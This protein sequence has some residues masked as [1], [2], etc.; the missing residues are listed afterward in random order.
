[1]CDRTGML[2]RPGT[3]SLR[4]AGV[5]IDPDNSAADAETRRAAARRGYCY[6]DLQHITDW[7]IMSSEF[8]TSVHSAAVRATRL[9]IACWAA[10][11]LSFLVAPQ[12]L[13]APVAAAAQVAQPGIVG[14]WAITVVR[15]DG[16]VERGNSLVF[17]VDGHVTSAGPGGSGGGTWSA[18]GP[19][20]FTYSIRTNYDFGY[21]LVTAKIAVSGDRLAGVG[22]ATAYDPQGT[23]LGGGQSVLAG[24][25]S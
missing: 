5:F 17:S 23:Q 11:A 19:R 18:A 9:V 4:L 15:A 3:T 2:G 22:R 12:A 10:L 6:V 8:R 1:M 16:T 13:A 25:R 7:T 21:V 20:Q 24:T 14:S